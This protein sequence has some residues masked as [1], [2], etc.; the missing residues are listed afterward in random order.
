MHYPKDIWPLTVLNRIN[1]TVL[2]DEILTLFAGMDDN[3]KEKLGCDR[4]LNRKGCPSMKD[5]LS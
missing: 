2:E 3:H 1:D 5:S 4:P